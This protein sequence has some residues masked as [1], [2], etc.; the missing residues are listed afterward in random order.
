MSELTG[1]PKLMPARMRL[2]EHI[3]RN[4]VI[5]VEPGTTQDH[6][7]DPAYWSLVASQFIPMTRLIVYPD[8]SSF[9]AEYLVIACAKNWAKVHEL[10]FKKL[11]SAEAENVPDEYEIKWRGNFNKHCVIRKSDGKV[12][13]DQCQTRDE[14]DVWLKGFV[15][16]AA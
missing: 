16:V 13:K 11:T 12:I 6:L 4:F 3:Q 7:K 9:Y 15:K 5:V 8:D 2:Q 1:S 14:A 10:S